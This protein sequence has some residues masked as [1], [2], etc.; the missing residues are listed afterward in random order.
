MSVEM[1]GNHNS[2]VEKRL[3]KRVRVKNLWKCPLIVLELQTRGIKTK[4]NFEGN[5]EGS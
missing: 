5:V 3:G 4:V 2:K 1:S